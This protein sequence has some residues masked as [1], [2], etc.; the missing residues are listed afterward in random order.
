MDA[1]VNE[2]TGVAVWL[3]RFP[4]GQPGWLL[5]PIDNRAQWT[6]EYTRQSGR[7]PVTR[8]PLLQVASTVT[9]PQYGQLLYRVFAV[10][11]HLLVIGD[12]AISSH[13][14]Q[15]QLDRRA[16]QQPTQ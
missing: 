7:N 1:A 15:I 3:Q 16:V 11:Q 10:R 12:R 8:H 5:R 13:D 4:A 9:D 6:I 14:R 2:G